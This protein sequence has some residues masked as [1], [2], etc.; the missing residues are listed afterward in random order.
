MASTTVLDKAQEKNAL[1]VSRRADRYRAREILWR[2]SSLDRQKTCGHHA[3]QDTVQIRRA[4]DGSGAGFSGVATCGSVWACPVCSEKINAERQS[5]LTQALENWLA[6]GGVGARYAAPKKGAEGPVLRTSGTGGALVFG[7]LTVRHHR[8]QSLARLWDAIS[9]AFNATTS[10]AGVEWN[11]SRRRNG[12]EGDKVRFG[13]RGIV[14]VVEVKHGANGWHPHIHFIMFLDRALSDVERQQLNDRM[15]ARWVNALAKDGLTASREH[16]I[17]LRP[18]FSAA[19][20]DYFAKAQ[21][22]H[23]TGTAGAA[24]EVTGSQSKQQGKGGRTPFQ[25]LRDIVAQG[26]ADDLDLWHEYERASKGRRQLTWSHGLKNLLDMEP[27]KT[28]EEIVEESLDGETVA[29]V[30]AS[31]FNRMAKAGQ[32]CRL[33]E[34]AE[35]PDRG[36]SLRAFLDEWECVRLEDLTHSAA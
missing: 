19:L 33:L 35:R 32:S 20:A 29:V 16:G 15:Y 1:R 17:D 23:V 4:A 34:L 22:T 10:G 14:R 11:G 9:G 18:V 28:D 21:Y 3:V 13:I 36:K 2:E 8:G 7:T 25:I 6:R 26:D 12:Y 24:Y 27:E 5:Y 30:T 31:D